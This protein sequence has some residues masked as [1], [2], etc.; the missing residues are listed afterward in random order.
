VI[1]VCRLSEIPDDSESGVVVLHDAAGG[2]SGTVG[3]RGRPPQ[4]LALLGGPGGGGG[5]VLSSSASS[6]QA[7]AIR[8]QERAWHAVTESVLQ[9]S[10]FC[11]YTK[12]IQNN[13]F[14]LVSLEK[15][16]FLYKTEKK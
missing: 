5:D 2:G 4:L 3:N 12:K 7:A 16:L 15:N 8:R 10:I 13:K 14:S 6:Q 11:G 9:Y 1:F